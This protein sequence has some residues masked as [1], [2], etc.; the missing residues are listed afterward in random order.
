[1]LSATVVAY[2]LDGPQ[3]FRTGLYCSGVGGPRPACRLMGHQ[4]ARGKILRIHAPEDAGGE[5]Q[6]RLRRYRPV[7]VHYNNRFYTT[8]T[9]TF[10]RPRSR[11]IRSFRMT[12][13]DIYPRTH[14]QPELVLA[15]RKI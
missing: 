3:R 14:G 7:H 2:R 11:D 4:A 10:P 13:V 12:A 6:L 9:N 5:P 8:Y 15:V 1:M